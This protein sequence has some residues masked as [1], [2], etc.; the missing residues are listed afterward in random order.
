MRINQGRSC[1]Q[2]FRDLMVIGHYDVHPQLS[3]F[4]HR[5]N[6]GNPAIHGHQ[7]VGPLVCQAAYGLHI[8]PI[9]F[10]KAMRNMNLDP[11]SEFAQKIG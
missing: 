11:R 4:G 2:P 10:I 1:G 5:F 8:Q 3:R 6:I 9:A 7:K